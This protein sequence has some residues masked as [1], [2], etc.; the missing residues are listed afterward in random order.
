MTAKPQSKC[1]ASDKGIVGGPLISSA[2]VGAK[3]AEA[4]QAELRQMARETAAELKAM[5]SAPGYALDDVRGVQ[6]GSPAARAR[7]I[8]N[9][10]LKKYRVRFD[11]LAKAATD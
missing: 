5:F 11:R 7:I 9:R 6:D 4:V 2:A 1:L 3:Y 8:L 10:L